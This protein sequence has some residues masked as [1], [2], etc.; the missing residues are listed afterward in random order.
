MKI[1]NEIESNVESEKVNEVNPAIVY[2][3]TMD[4]IVNKDDEESLK[5]WDYL[6]SLS[7]NECTHK[8]VDET[9]SWIYPYDHIDYKICEYCSWH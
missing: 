7:L 4:L 6:Y 5:V 3:L 2:K 8:H 9:T 1:K